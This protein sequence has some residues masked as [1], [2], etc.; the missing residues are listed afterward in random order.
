MDGH[1]RPVHCKQP[2]DHPGGSPASVCGLDQPPRFLLFWAEVACWSEL[3]PSA[4]KFAVG[5]IPTA[6]DFRLYQCTASH[7]CALCA[8]T[9]IQSPRGE[10]TKA[11]F[12][13]PL[14]SSSPRVVPPMD[15][16]RRPR[17][18]PRIL[19]IRNVPDKEAPD[20]PPPP[21]PPHQ[22]QHP[23]PREV[24]QGG[25]LDRPLPP[26]APGA[27]FLQ[28]RDTA[29]AAAEHLHADVGRDDVPAGPPPA[30]PAPRPRRRL[31]RHQRRGTPSSALSIARMHRPQMN[32][33]SPHTG[34]S[35]PNRAASDK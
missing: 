7:N 33:S 23:P 19:H 25:L 27:Q 18:V 26:A 4:R 5:K 34:C 14:F 12:L 29:G 16:S 28:V 17:P 10:A 11:Y 22:G 21:D 31:Q 15:P 8:L 9:R 24:V 3:A 32:L 35:V 30:G 20:L 2:L 6:T 13:S 1:A